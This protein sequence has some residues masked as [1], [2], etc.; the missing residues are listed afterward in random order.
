MSLN[1]EGFALM[2]AGNYE[3]AL[4]L[5]EQSVAGLSGSGSTTEA[6]ASYNLAY[7]RFAL[8][9]CDGVLPLLDRSQAVQG[10]RKEIDALRRDWEQR[11]VASADDEK[12]SG[13]G[14]AGGKGNDD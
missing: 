13:K 8:G 1:D 6:Y 2:R 10:E 12:G 11:C 14:R 3:G 5:L 9:G 7:T 4:P